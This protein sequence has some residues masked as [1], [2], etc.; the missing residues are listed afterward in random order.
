[1][2]ESQESKIYCYQHQELVMTLLNFQDKRLQCNYLTYILMYWL[3]IIS[4]KSR[5]QTITIDLEC[6]QVY[7]TKKSSKGIQEV[8]SKNREC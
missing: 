1:M 5:L 2:S 4:I 7:D 6:S 3:K 8:I